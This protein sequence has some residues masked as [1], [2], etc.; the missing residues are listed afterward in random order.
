MQRILQRII[1]L[2]HYAVLKITDAV[3]NEA[4][5]TATKP[6]NAGPQVRAGTKYGYNNN[7]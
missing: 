6:G 3:A 2:K 7:L 5:N 4:E 1:P